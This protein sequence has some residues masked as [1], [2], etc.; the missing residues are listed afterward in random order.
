MA[1]TI[2]NSVDSGKTFFDISV[3]TDQIGMGIEADTPEKMTA[4]FHRMRL[5]DTDQ[6]KELLKSNRKI[7]LPV[8]NFLT[9]SLSESR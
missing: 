2:G 5:T 3:N 8:K 9:R 1:D 7:R 4:T 6:V